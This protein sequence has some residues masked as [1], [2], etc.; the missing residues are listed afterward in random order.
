M[1]YKKQLATGALALSLLVGGSTIY[2][3]SPQDLG[4]KSV[5]KFYQ[6][7]NK[8]REREGMELRKQNNTIGVIEAL[9]SPGFTVS[10]T[11]RKT[12]I[13]YSVDVKTDATTIYKKDGL[14]A[15]LPDLSVGQKVIVQGPLDKTTNILNAKKVKIITKDF[16]PK[17]KKELKTAIK[18]N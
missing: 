5:G 4:I 17:V 12:K 13:A 10:V 1:K 18:T 2:A 11:N 7:Y 3:A 15:S 9:T 16:A 14:E 6:K 8:N